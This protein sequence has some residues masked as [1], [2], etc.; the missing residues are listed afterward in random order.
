MVKIKGPFKMN[1]SMAG[2]SFYTMR[3]SDKVIMRTKGGA[4]KKKIKNY[5]DR[6]HET[7][8]KRLTVV[9]SHI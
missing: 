4:T 5:N 6:N 3:G 2:I 9:K 8:R 1:G 7:F